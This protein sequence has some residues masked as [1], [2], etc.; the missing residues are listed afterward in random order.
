MKRVFIF[1]ALAGLC[2]GVKAQD[3][4]FGPKVGW[5]V[6]NISNAGD[7]KNKIGV[8]L[9]VFA[10]W[11]VNDILGIQPELVY[12]RQGTRWKKDGVKA[13]FRVNNLNIPILARLYVLDGLSVDLG[14]QLGFALNGKTVMKEGGSTL[15]QKEKH[16][17]A[18]EF[19]W[20]LGLSYNWNDFV[21]STRYNIGLSNVVDKDVAGGNNKNH[22]FQLSLGYR[23]SDLF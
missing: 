7:S 8:H 13:K 3:I 2:F 6:T 1:V 15:K 12:S 21:I 4:A 11:R 19:G 17:N 14:P 9:G 22:V 16:V 23:F 18:V 5:N 10:E 20:A